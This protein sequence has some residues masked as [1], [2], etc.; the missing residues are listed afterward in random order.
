MSE[1][2]QSN[3]IQT[4]RALT[5][6]QAQVQSSSSSSSSLVALVASPLLASP[7]PAPA[8]SPAISPTIISHPSSIQDTIGYSQSSNQTNRIAV[9]H[10]ASSA[11]HSTGIGGIKKKHKMRMGTGPSNHRLKLLNPPKWYDNY[12]FKT[13]DVL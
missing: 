6:L 4:A 8:S 2:L 1:T 9:S 3:R 5:K 10:T 11:R 7:A 12:N 13:A